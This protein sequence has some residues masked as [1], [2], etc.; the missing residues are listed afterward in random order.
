MGKYLI[1]STYIVDAEVTQQAIMVEP[2]Q[3]PFK[4]MEK[5]KSF[6]DLY[7]PS[8]NGNVKQLA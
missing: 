2:C 5:I 4:I 6:Q 3:I 1:L 7:I 8:S